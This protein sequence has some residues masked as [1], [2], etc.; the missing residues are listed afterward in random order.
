[1][2]PDLEAPA[3]LKVTVSGHGV[4]PPDRGPFINL[5]LK[6]REERIQEASYETYPCP[7]C[8]ACGNG[9]CEI[10]AGKLI[11]EA[12]SVRR[13]HLV[14][15]VGPLPAHRRHCYG[16]ALLALVDALRKGDASTQNS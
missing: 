4:N 2:G 16:L 7:G 9:L 1:M 14:E 8:H 10:I 3:A 13:E 5:H 6:T 15:K 12:G 11:E